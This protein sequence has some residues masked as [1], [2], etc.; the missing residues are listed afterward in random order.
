[1]FEHIDN[2]FSKREK[3]TFLHQIFHQKLSIATFDK[4]HKN[5]A[6]SKEPLPFPPSFQTAKIDPDNI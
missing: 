3:K 5:H 6:Y 1:M 4:S 2:N